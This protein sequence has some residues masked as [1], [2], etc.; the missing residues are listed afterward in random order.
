MK[1][2]RQFVLIGLCH[3]IMASAAYAQFWHGSDGPMSLTVDSTRITIKFDGGLSPDDQASVL[4]SYERIIAIIDD[5]EALD[6]FLVCSLQI[7]T[8][9]TAFVDSVR[10]ADGVYLAEPYYR[11]TTGAPMPVGECFC[12]AFNDTI[13]NDLIDSINAAFGVVLDYGITGLPNT[14][15]LRN[16]DSSGLGLLE[17]ANTYFDLP[18]TSYSHPDF[19]ASIEPTGFYKLYDYY[20]GYQPHIQKVVGQFNNGPT[21]WDFAGVDKPIIVA[22]VDDGVTLHEDLPAERILSGYDVSSHPPDYNA[23]PGGERGH[24]MGC[25]GIIATSHSTDS[26]AMLDPNTGVISIAPHT[27]IMPIKI[28]NDDGSSTRI[29]W[30]NV[31]D[32]IGYAWTHGAQ[33]LS[34]SWS[35]SKYNDSGYTVLD[36]ALKAAFTQGRNGLGCPLIFS[37]GNFG[38]YYPGIIAYP[39]KLDSCF[40]VG[41]TTLDDTLWYYSC[42]GPALDIAAPSGNICLQ[43]NFWA[44][45]QMGWAGYNIQ[46]REMCN[47]GFAWQCPDTAEEY[48]DDYDCRFGGTSAACPQVAATAA[49]LVSRDSLLTAQQVY[50]ILRYS[51]VGGPLPDSSKMDTLYTQWGRLDAFRAM[52]A[53]TR[54]DVNNDGVLNIG[55]PVWLTAYLFRGGPPP[56]LDNATGDANCDGGINI[57]DVVLLTSHIFRGG[58]APY[59]CYEYDY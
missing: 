12:V 14:F 27:L 32:A 5:P 29:S 20:I 45:D 42:R 4:R 7:V 13:T 9:Y 53:I 17:L 15:V 47:V 11:S 26:T 16:T 24:G 51:A 31:A 25:A 52:L 46:V 36:N 23:S 2:Y 37:A 1:S 49:L 10:S 22:V 39:A 35:S 48:D 21:V 19:H 56:V 43:G 33:V 8:G 3:I 6:E 57:G 28:F 59:I 41:A 38:D 55:D 54:G 18:Q 40:A 34:N 44:L 58:P 50:D 30:G